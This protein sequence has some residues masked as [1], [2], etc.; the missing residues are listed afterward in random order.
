MTIPNIISIIRLAMVPYIVWT[1]L[2]GRLTLA[3]IL[4]VVV[5]ISDGVDGYIARKFNQRTELGAYLDPL[6]DKTLLVTMFVALG[7][8]EAIPQWLV[9]IVLTR[10]VLILSG[11]MV[12]FVIGNPIEIKPLFVSKANTAVQIVLV[13]LALAIPA[14][15]LDLSSVQSILVWTCA[16]LTIAS[17][18]AYFAAWTRH[19][20]G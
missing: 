16:V 8:L 12:A 19:V 1:L 4:F 14:F 15:G 7:Y 3:F 2:E 13:S 6:A 11:V 10:D 9:I 20:S 5:G 17:A 18:F